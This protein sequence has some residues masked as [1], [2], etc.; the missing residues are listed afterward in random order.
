MWT[1]LTKVDPDAIDIDQEAAMSRQI[2]FMEQEANSTIKFTLVSCAVLYLCSLP[3]R[4][5]QNWLSSSVCRRP[6]IQTHS[7]L[8][9]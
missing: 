7:D 1:H 8:D 2:A 9:N 6:G 3:T 5:V 4:F